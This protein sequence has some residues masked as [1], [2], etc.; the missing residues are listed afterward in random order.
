MI[1]HLLD[2]CLSGWLG[3]GRSVG[4]TG[5]GTAVTPL[6]DEMLTSFRE[7]CKSEWRPP[8]PG[9]TEDTLRLPTIR[10]RLLTVAATW[11]LLYDL[12]PYDPEWERWDY[13]PPTRGGPLTLPRRDPVVEGSQP[14][15]EFELPEVGSRTESE[16][17]LFQKFK[18]Y[19]KTSGKSVQGVPGYLLLSLID[20]ELERTLDQWD[21]K[22]WFEPG[23]PGSQLYGAD[24]LAN[25]L[26]WLAYTGDWLA[27]YL[28]ED[29]QSPFRDG[30][31]GFSPM[32]SDRFGWI[33]AKV[34]PAEATTPAAQRNTRE[35]WD[36]WTQRLDLLAQV[37]DANYPDQ[38]LLTAWRLVAR[39]LPDPWNRTTARKQ[40]R[41]RGRILKADGTVNLDWWTDIARLW[42]VATPAARMWLS[43]LM[44]DRIHSAIVGDKH[45]RNAYNSFLRRFKRGR[46]HGPAWSSVGLLRHFRNF[47]GEPLGIDSFAALIDSVR[48]G[49]PV[50]GDPPEGLKGDDPLVFIDIV[51]GK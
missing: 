26:L 7:W 23:K 14:A 10:H 11:W 31:R 49:Y 39:L 18:E 24:P 19:L 2:V 29:R 35:R 30:R 44:L 43:P 34:A 25:S 28:A 12:G 3:A 16:N 6:F 15:R 42:G 41:P 1:D 8:A 20:E 46:A 45:L 27:Y 5:K 32:P 51:Q 36:F 33:L 50:S 47:D 9:I 38:P 21:R 22:K 40:R 13:P 37:N 17:S 4:G 48:F